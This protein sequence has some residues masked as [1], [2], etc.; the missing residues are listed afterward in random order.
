MTQILAERSIPL[1]Q[2]SSP[3]SWASSLAAITRGD[4]KLIHVGRSCQGLRNNN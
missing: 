3:L 1:F 2:L 4:A